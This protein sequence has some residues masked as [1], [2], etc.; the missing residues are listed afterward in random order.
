MCLMIVRHFTLEV[1]PAN[2]KLRVAERKRE[3]AAGQVAPSRAGGQVKTRNRPCP[4]GNYPAARRSGLVDS[5]LPM[6]AVRWPGM[7]R[8]MQAGTP[9]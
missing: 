8:G 3:L 4:S 1:D 9:R 6:G 2:Y 7:P 5:C